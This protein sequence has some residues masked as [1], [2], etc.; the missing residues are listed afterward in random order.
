MSWKSGGQIENLIFLLFEAWMDGKLAMVVS[1][2]E[3]PFGTAIKN[4][5]CSVPFEY[6]TIKPPFWKLF[7][8]CNFEHVPPIVQK[9]TAR[10]IN[11]DET[12]FSKM[13]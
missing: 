11:G 13:P 9:C 12:N 6:R 3:C 2:M 5:G 8:K 4:Y 10:Q 7:F 1:A